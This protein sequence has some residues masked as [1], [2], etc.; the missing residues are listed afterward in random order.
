MFH[1]SIHLSYLS[2][3]FFLPSSL[4]HFCP[5]FHL[6]ICPS[7]RLICHHRLPSFQL[8]GPGHYIEK[9]FLVY[10]YLFFSFPSAFPICSV[11]TTVF[12]KVSVATEKIQW[13]RAPV[14]AE[15]L[16]SDSLAPTRKLTTIH[17]PVPGSQFLLISA[18]T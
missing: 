10:F 12:K 2:F 1:L 5:S 14:L 17:A 11:L 16:G 15:D 6:S 18:G 13:L 4:P 7:V 8:F 3:F 9:K